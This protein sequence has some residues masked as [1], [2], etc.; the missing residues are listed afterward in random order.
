M[1]TTNASQAAQII[2]G[3]ETTFIVGTKSLMYIIVAIAVSGWVG[4]LSLVVGAVAFFVLR[5]LLYRTRV[6]ASA[7]ERNN[8][9]IAHF[10][11]EHS[12]GMKAVKSMALELPVTKKAIAYFEAA[13]AHKPKSQETKDWLRDAKRQLKAKKL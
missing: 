4:V 11:G 2:Y 7:M 8:R 9:A 1:L 10:T 6:I 3:L 5:P 13:L 12:I